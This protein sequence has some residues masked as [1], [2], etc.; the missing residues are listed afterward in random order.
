M[1]RQGKCSDG[2]GRPVIGEG[3]IYSL[4]AEHRSPCNRDIAEPQSAIVRGRPVFEIGTNKVLLSQLTINSLTTSVTRLRAHES[5][6]VGR[7]FLEQK[8]WRRTIWDFCNN[9]GTKR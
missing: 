1:R 6:V 8:N 5:A 3:K 7:I 9:I 2:D 4:S